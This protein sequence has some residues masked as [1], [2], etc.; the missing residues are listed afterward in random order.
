M[1]GKWILNSWSALPVF[2]FFKMGRAKLTDAFSYSQSDLEYTI[3]SGSAKVIALGITYPY[4]VVRSR[5]QVRPFFHFV[6][7]GST[8]LAT[9]PSFLSELTL[10]TI[11]HHRTNPT[12]QS[13]GTSRYRTASSKRTGEKAF[14]LS[15]TVWL[16]IAYAFCRARV[17]RFL[18]RLT[19][20]V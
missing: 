17:V 19:L 13:N 10:P 3:M 8:L 18:F 1:Q 2:A 12:I 9:Y 7:S 14:E 5:I 6:Q 4:Q 20:A 15:T 11:L 16:R